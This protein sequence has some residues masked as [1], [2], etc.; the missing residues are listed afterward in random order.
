M[1]FKEDKNF[2]RVSINI[3]SYSA[4][5]YWG[6]FLL[7]NGFYETYGKG[8]LVNSLFLLNSGLVIFFTSEI[9]A[10]FIRKRRTNA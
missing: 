6:I 9:L 3:A 1:F 8:P 2:D 5:I 4:F 10:K 7:I